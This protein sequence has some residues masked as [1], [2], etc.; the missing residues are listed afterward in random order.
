MQGE[1]GK[2]RVISPRML[3]RMKADTV[4]LKDRQDAAWIRQA[5]H[6]ED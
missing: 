5:F 1:L 3:V 6:L 4:R 2:A